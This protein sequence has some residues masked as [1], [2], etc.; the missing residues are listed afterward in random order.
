[1]SEHLSLWPAERIAFGLPTGP[2]RAVLAA[3]VDVAAKGTRLG[4]D[5]KERLLE[6]LLVREKDGSTAAGGLAIPHVKTT[7]LKA[8]L[9]ALGVFPDGIDFGAVDGEKVQA[10]FLLLSPTAMAAEH[11]ARLRWIAGVAR[12]PD[13]MRFLAR[14]RTPQDA[15]ALLEEMGT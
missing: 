12:K 7:E 5:R 13:F 10:T 4:P 14:T 9:A 8:P 3:L 2:K 11:V 6:A 15:R 1:M